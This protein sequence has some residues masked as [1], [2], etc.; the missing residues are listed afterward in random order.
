MAGTQ[1]GDE[2]MS[3]ARGLKN[4]VPVETRQLLYRLQ[5]TFRGGL[6]RGDTVYYDACYGWFRRFLEY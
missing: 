1:R 3:M 5:G 6:Y 4:A 2:S